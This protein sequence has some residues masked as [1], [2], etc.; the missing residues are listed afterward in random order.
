MLPDKN[1]ET[2]SMEP[3]ELTITSTGKLMQIKEYDG[4][5][6]VQPYPHPA[7][8]AYIPFAPEALDNNKHIEMRTKLK[9]G[10]KYKFTL[11]ISDCEKT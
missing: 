8:N 9:L 3:I 11:V 1:K 2:K 5:I 10:K 6:I 7:F 4:I